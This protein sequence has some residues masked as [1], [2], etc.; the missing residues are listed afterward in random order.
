M[1]VGNLCGDYSD[2]NLGSRGINLYGDRDIKAEWA[3]N[4]VRG[5]GG[6]PPGGRLQLLPGWRAFR[7]ALFDKEDKGVTGKVWRVFETVVMVIA[8]AIIIAVIGM[9]MYYALGWQLRAM[10]IPPSKEVQRLQ[11]AYCG[12]GGEEKLRQDQ[13]SDRRLRNL[14]RDELCGLNDIVFRSH[15][16]STFEPT[17]LEDLPIF[18]VICH[19]ENAT[20]SEVIKDEWQWRAYIDLGVLECPLNW[21]YWS[22][23]EGFLLEKIAAVGGHAIMLM[24]TY[25]IASAMAREATETVA[26]EEAVLMSVTAKVI[27]FPSDRKRYN[28]GVP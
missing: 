8:Y 15:Y 19:T 25:E 1:G 23:L 27:R 2:G 3:A 6:R 7:R 11:M 18:Q 22:T 28:W 10:T 24:E 9:V 21:Y 26:E 5:E 13:K 16:Q 17:E 14:D 4:Q 12:C 20:G